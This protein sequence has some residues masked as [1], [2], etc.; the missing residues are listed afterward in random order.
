MQRFIIIGLVTA[1]LG[2]SPTLG[3]L[4]TQM[5]TFDI[6][7][8]NWSSGANPV[9]VATG[10]AGDNGGFLQ[11]SRPPEAPFH[12]ATYNRTQ[13]TGNY[14]AAGITA[15]EMDLNYIDGP[16]AFNARLMIWGAGGTWA[17]TGLTPISSGWNRYA[18]GL[19]SADL[20]FVN[21]DTSG[22]PTGAGGGS[23]LLADTLQQ[24]NI[25]QLRHDYPTPTPPGSHPDHIS[26]TLG[27][28]NVQAVPEPATLLYML[29]AGGGLM[30]T[31]ARR[32]AR[33]STDW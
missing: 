30:L 5:D 14:L 16:D 20:T 6:S 7:T 22:P 12:I 15:I 4:L 8:M 26:A 19:T 2:I 3:D 24:V 21:L 9:Y 13:W 1:T 27:I 29:V 18:F 28:D 17:S 31:R 11:L 10:G 23:G 33:R 32:T 25:F